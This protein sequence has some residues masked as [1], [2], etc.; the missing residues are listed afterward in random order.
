MNKIVA[1]RTLPPSVTMLRV[2]AP[3]I[4]RKYQA[5]Q[6]VI[7]RVKQSGERIPLTVAEVDKTGLISL[8]VQEVGYTT[9]LL[10]NLSEGEFIPDILGPLGKP[11]EIKNFGRVVVVGGGLGTAVAYPEA[12]ALKEAGNELIT[13]IGVRNKDLIIFEEELRSISTQSIVA[14]DDGSRGHHG[15]VSD[16]LRNIIEEGKH[17]DRV[18]ASGPPIMMKAISNLTRPYGITTMVS[19]NPIM[20][21]GTGMCGACRFS[22]SGQTK[23]GCVDG[24][25]FD[26]HAVDFDQLIVRLRMYVAQERNILE[27][28]RCKSEIR[29]VSA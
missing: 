28:H 10:C 3:E 8:V 18:L 24:P 5:G 7:L 17:I 27:T 20:L 22:V 29:G 16:V 2:M 11:S 23:F 12:R 19:L 6:F 4:A 15:F 25:S 1:R 14:T 9:Q 26:G 21:D 13:I